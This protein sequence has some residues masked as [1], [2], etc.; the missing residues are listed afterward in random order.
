[1]VFWLIIV[2]GWMFIILRVQP[3]WQVTYIDMWSIRSNWCNLSLLMFTIHA[4]NAHI[5]TTDAHIWYWLNVTFNKLCDS[6]ANILI[7]LYV[8]VQFLTVTNLG[9]VNTKI[10]A[11]D[12]LELVSSI[13][14]LRHPNIL[15]LVGYCAEFEQ[16]LLVYK[17]FSKRTLHYIL[18]C[19]DDFNKKLSWNARVQVALGAAR[20]LE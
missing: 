11:D 20:A 15:E 3:F 6:G 9:N 5:D 2:C 17:Y 13:S 14:E 16:R 4:W 19:Q 8:I 7:W 1:M 12:F 18:H 10:P